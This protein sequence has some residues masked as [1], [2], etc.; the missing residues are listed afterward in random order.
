MNCQHNNW[1]THSNGV[2][3]CL[4]CPLIIIPSKLRELYLKSKLKIVEEKREEVREDE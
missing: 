2:R 3:E 1:I 4:G